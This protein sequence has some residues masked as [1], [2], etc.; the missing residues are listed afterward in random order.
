VARLLED[1]LPRDQLVLCNPRWLDRDAGDRPAQSQAAFFMEAKRVYM[2]LRPHV[3]RL[4]LAVTDVAPYAVT[5]PRLGFR[6]LSDPQVTVEDIVYHSFVLDLGPA[7][8][9][10]WL[11][12]L[13]ETELGIDDDEPVL[14]PEQLDVR[15]RGRRVR[16]SR[17]E[18]GVLQTLVTHQ[19]RPVSRA[20]LIEQ[21]WA[22]P[23]AAAATSS[24]R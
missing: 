17:L 4:Y 8:V 16:L 12:W 13:I 24:T 21:V 18:F 2:E 23:T 3:R 11:S 20:T 1:R 10:G 6:P 22:P 9:D 5:F 14:D 7:S 15:L 19:G